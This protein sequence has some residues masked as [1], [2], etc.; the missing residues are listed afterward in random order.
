MF[1]AEAIE[2]MTRPVTIFEYWRPDDAEYDDSYQKREMGK[3]V[4]HEF[5]VSYENVGDSVGNYSTAIIELPNGQIV[6][7]P[8][9]MIQFDD[10]GKE[11]G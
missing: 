1:I 11:N 9:E 4:F 3:G 5:G 2:I 8:V 7:E 6:N 10:K